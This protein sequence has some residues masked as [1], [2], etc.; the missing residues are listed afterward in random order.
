VRKELVGSIIARDQEIGNGLILLDE[1]VRA[2]CFYAYLY[3]HEI[4]F[5]L[6]ELI[7]V[8]RAAPFFQRGVIFMP[9]Y[10][11]ALNEDLLHIVSYFL[12][13]D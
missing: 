1:R 13:S 4:K 10:T 11:A 12:A 8:L 5:P 6:K 7:K 9:L 2:L 3:C